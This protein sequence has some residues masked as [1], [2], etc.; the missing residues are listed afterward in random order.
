[1]MLATRRSAPDHLGLVSV[2]LKSVGPHPPAHFAYAVR[3]TVLELGTITGLTEAVY[4][5]VVR[6][7]TAGVQAVCTNQS[8]QICGVQKKQNRSKNRSLWD[9][10]DQFGQGL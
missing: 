6:V 10:A 7:E 8:D 4:L 3:N 1:M 2:E 9:T 5:R